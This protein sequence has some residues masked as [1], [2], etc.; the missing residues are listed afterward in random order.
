MNPLHRASHAVGSPAAL[1]IVAASQISGAIWGFS[2]GWMKW[3]NYGLSVAA[4]AAAIVVQAAQNRDTE[5][6]QQKLDGLIRAI[7]K[8][9][10]NLQGI[11]KR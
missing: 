3:S 10:D 6:I 7:D 5:A 1:L 2:D 11:E 9:D 4:I 8:A